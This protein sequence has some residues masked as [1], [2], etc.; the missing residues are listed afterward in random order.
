MGE[1]PYGVFYCIAF[2]CTIIPGVAV[3]FRRLHDIGKSGWNILWGL[4]PIV[5]PF[6]LLY[7]TVKDSQIGDNQYGP[8]VK[9]I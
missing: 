2:I 4:V 7:L 9:Y 3:S 1:L 5:G 8:S 6:L